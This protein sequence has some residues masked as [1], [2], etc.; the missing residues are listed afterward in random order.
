MIF[1][2]WPV[3]VLQASDRTWT[4]KVGYARFSRTVQVVCARWV[5]L[6]LG[7]DVTG[8]VGLGETWWAKLRLV[9]SGILRICFENFLGI[10]EVNE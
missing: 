4:G 1:Q 8:Q 3:R 6:I 9:E 10:R 5:M 7:R 2:V